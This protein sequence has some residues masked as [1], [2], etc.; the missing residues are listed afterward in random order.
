MTSDECVELI[1]YQDA[2]ISLSLYIYIF[3]Y[4]YISIYMHARQKDDQNTTTFCA[5][6]YH[7]IW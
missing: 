5:H 4:L 1:D 3:V 2:G 6:A 7:R